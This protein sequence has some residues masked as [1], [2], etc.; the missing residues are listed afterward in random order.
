MKRYLITGAK[1][2]IGRHLALYLQA[3]EPR[4]EVIAAGREHDLA[5]PVACDE[6][7]RQA[8]A[9]DYVF[10][11]AD[12]SGNARWSAANSATQFFANARIS[13]NVLDAV[14]RLQRQARLVG[15]SSLWAYPA[16]V[17]LARES[18]ISRAVTSEILT[19]PLIPS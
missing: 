18:R 3:E 19:M 14:S 2:F 7:F 16:S 9:L 11:L 15:F 8:G 10:H 5:D 1:G 13:L 12:V 17:G 4:A 6:L